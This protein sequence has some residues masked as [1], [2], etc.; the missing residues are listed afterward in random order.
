MKYKEYKEKYF[1]MQEN[2]TLWYNELT[3]KYVYD[4]KYV[5]RNM[6]RSHN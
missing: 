4:I 2:R 3:I 5:S 6:L 1:A